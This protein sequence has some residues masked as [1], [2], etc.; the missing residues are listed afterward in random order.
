MW[1]EQVVRRNCFK[2]KFEIFIE[3]LLKNGTVSKL[4]ITWPGIGKKSRTNYII[5]CDIF[6]NRNFLKE[7]KD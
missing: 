1:L 6:I 2:P 5:F 7:N 3:L 4:S